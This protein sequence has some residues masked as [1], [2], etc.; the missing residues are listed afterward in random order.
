M[1]IQSVRAVHPIKD[2]LD[3]NVQ[4]SPGQ[5]RDIG[6]QVVFALF[7]QRRTLKWYK[8]HIIFTAVALFDKYLIWLQQT[9]QKLTWVDVELRFMVCLYI[10]IKYNL[11]MD[12]PPFFTDL[13][14]RQFVHD[15]LLE[16]ASLVEEEVL[17]HVLEFKI[18]QPTIYDVAKD[19]LDE[20]GIRDLLIF[21]AGL[22]HQQRQPGVV[23]N[24]NVRE[25]Y[26]L[27]IRARGSKQ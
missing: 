6:M 16:V 20:T 26:S 19:K 5:W 21:Y 2:V 1:Y 23:Y 4:I 25:L 9:R 11:I 14:D 10:S 22:P 12:V 3:Y 7:N 13:V 18:Y 15:N 17:E 24:A 8:H 27:F